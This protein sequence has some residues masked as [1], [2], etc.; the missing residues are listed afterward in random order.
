MAVRRIGG[1]VCR[2]S[3][4]SMIFQ[5]SELIIRPEEPYQVLCV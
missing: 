3:D 4:T 2:C 1:F 5:V